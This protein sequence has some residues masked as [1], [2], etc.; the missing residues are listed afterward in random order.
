MSSLDADE[1]RVHLVC[2]DA[3]L[4]SC[5]SELHQVFDVRGDDARPVLLPRVV[6][7]DCEWRP[8]DFSSSRCSDLTAP[9]AALSS[10]TEHSVNNIALLQ[11]CSGTGDVY[12]IRT[13]L[14][15]SLEPLAWLL[16]DARILKT[17]VGIGDDALRISRAFPVVSVRGC[18][19]LRDIAAR[20]NKHMSV[21]SAHA[22]DVTRQGPSL[23]SLAL[24]VCGAELSKTQQR[25]DW[26]A[27]ELSFE[28]VQYAAR[29]A[30][31]S[32]AVFVRL[33]AQFQADR[34]TRLHAATVSSFSTAVSAVPAF[35]AASG[36]D[37]L[38]EEECMSAFVLGLVDRSRATS[39]AISHPAVASVIAPSQP[40]D[41][42]T[43]SLPA[44]ASATS[45]AAAAE[46]KRLRAEKIMNLFSR[47][48][49]LYDNCKILSP[50]GDL[51]CVANRKKLDWYLAR[52]LATEENGAG[53]RN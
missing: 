48:T 32:R 30:H 8:C 52:G 27:A 36:H 23:R 40:G 26:A 45:T 24:S 2:N 13:H 37:T 47:K 35:A 53:L 41:V 9:S 38:P 46:R 39:S 7:L 31:F 22:G 18:V 10:A 43:V 34:A 42:V 29:D 3:Q 25:S 21:T 49:P 11:L 12:L 16:A 14:C 5:A 50:A 20:C 28:Q 33:Y 17:G 15:S 1:M 51:M 6:G 4:H 19:D 44:A